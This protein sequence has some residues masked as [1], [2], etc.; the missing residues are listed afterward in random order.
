MRLHDAIN[1][2]RGLVNLATNPTE[3]V[4]LC[5][6]IAFPAF[7]PSLELSLESSFF[8]SVSNTICKMCGIDSPLS[9]RATLQPEFHS[10]E[11]EDIV[12]GGL[13]S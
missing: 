4:N 11:E 12:A 13:G 10:G 2:F 9:K 7:L 1:K 6:Y 3:V 8:E 5:T